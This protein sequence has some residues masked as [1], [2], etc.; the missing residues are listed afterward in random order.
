[1]TVSCTPLPL[2]ELWAT[3]QFSWVVSPTP[4]LSGHLLASGVHFAAGAK[5]AK[6]LGPLEPSQALLR[7]F[8]EWKHVM[9]GS[10]P[11]VPNYLPGWGE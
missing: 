5:R 8:S 11:A 6:T 4:E 3:N 2:G 7:G 10:A 1:M 9:S